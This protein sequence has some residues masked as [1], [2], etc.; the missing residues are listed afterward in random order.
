LAQK[1]AQRHGR[2][3]A[4]GGHLLLAL[5]T[6]GLSAPS[7]ALDALG[8]PRGGILEDLRTELGETRPAAA[9]NGHGPAATAAPHAA[10]PQATAVRREEA[11]PEPALYR[12]LREAALRGKLQGAVGRDTEIFTIHQILA[13]K[14]K[15]NVML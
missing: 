5:L 11:R 13:R 3:P 1:L 12:D 14:N 9:G 6:D 10:A 15:N 7:R 4:T 8:L 2:G